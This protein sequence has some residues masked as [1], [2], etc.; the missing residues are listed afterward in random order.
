MNSSSCPA[1]YR[2][3]ILVVVLVCL[4]APAMAQQEFQL[5]LGAYD[6]GS[7]ITG[8]NFDNGALLGFRYG[9][10][11]LKFFGTEFSYT[12]IKDLEDK[13]R[14]F[15]GNAHVLD[16]NFLVQIPVSKI[17][18]FATVGIGSI[19]GKTDSILRLRRTFAWNVGGGLKVRKIAGPVGFRVDVRYYNVPDG[20]EFLI[21]NPRKIDFTFAEVS[22]GLLFTF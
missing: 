22:G 19:I 13:Q 21:T 8:T 5:F 6:P 12:F 14:A 9:G 2:P 4:S 16:T 20:V 3:L 15:D 7:E 10:S 17:V 11:F 18:P 1:F